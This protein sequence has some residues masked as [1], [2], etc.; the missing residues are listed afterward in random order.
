MTSIL[1][2]AQILEGKYFPSKR[3]AKHHQ[4]LGKTVVLMLRM[5]KLIFG[6][7]KVIVF[8]SGFFVEKGVVEL[9]DRGV[10]GG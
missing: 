10:Y 6:S 9:E 8:D 2:K 3:G 1:W 4:E 5:I 7:G